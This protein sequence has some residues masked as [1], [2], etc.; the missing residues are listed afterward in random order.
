MNKRY[1][2]I[3]KLNKHIFGLFLFGEMA[4][5]LKWNR[6]G[7]GTWSWWGTGYSICC[8][9]V[10]CFCGGRGKRGTAVRKKGVGATSTRKKGARVLAHNSFALGCSGSTRTT[11]K[12]TPALLTQSLFPWLKNQ[13]LQRTI[14]VLVFVMLLLTSS[15]TRGRRQGKGRFWERVNAGGKSRKGDGV[16]H[17]TRNVDA[18]HST[19]H[20][21]VGEGKSSTE[22]PSGRLCY[23]KLWV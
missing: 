1:I 15:W 9:I 3:E 21:H 22:F 16:T 11:T 7:M 20:V 17:T 18:Q 6:L 4:F 12:T 2:I 14:E 10:D 23:Y 13:C 8:V 5:C 19:V